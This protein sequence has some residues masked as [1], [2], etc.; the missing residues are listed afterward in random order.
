VSADVWKKISAEVSVG[1]EN[2]V[3]PGSIRIRVSRNDG[4]I[5]NKLGLKLFNKTA[6]TNLP[7][8]NP[9]N[10]KL[11]LFYLDNI[12][13]NYLMIVSIINY[14]FPD[15][16]KPCE[17]DDADYSTEEEHGDKEKLTFNV[18]FSIEEWRLIHPREKVYHEKRGPRTYNIMTP[19]E[20]SNVVQDHFFL[21]TRLP[22]SLSFK[23][24]NITLSGVNFLTLNG[25]CSECGSYFQ[26]TIDSVP[27]VDTRLV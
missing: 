4:D 21:H 6:Q 10:R 11:S 3:T 25:R 14:L 24:A 19:F 8:A 18:T 7:H 2:A 20:W 5:Q 23:K 12:I 1:L 9:T 16:S 26:G 22:C 27:A 13:I 17:Y 15:Y